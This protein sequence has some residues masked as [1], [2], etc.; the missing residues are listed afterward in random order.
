MS[1]PLRIE[2]SGAVY[3]VMN[4]G[5]ARQA[6]FLEEKDHQSF[7]STLGEAHRLWA[8]EVFSYCLMKN[9]YHVCLRTP[10]GNLS[11][12]MR[13]VD[14]LYTQRFNRYHRRDGSL[15]RGRYKAILVDKDE[16]LA[17]MVRYKVMLMAAPGVLFGLLSHTGTDWI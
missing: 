8:I 5:S 2:F 6:T 10:G 9:H 15:F 1:R 17:Q 3:H 12:V 11:R 16:Y 14:G 13:H 4:R 7:L